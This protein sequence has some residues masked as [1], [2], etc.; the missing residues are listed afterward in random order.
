MIA[1]KL[2]TD[3]YN[4][5][6]LLFRFIRSFNDFVYEIQIKQA[7]MNAFIVRN[8]TM[9]FD[10]KWWITWIFNTKFSEC[11]EIYAMPEAWRSTKE[12]IRKRIL[13]SFVWYWPNRWWLELTRRTQFYGE[14]KRRKIYGEEEREREKKRKRRDFLRGRCDYKNLQARISCKK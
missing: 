6:D 10:P 4:E 2:N 8:A 5:F 12:T 7:V 9:L 11:V 13:F 14:D 1:S 3:I